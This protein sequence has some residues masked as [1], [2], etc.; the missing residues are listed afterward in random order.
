MKHL[1]PAHPLEVAI[2]RVGGVSKLAL[3]LGVAQSTISNWRARGTKIDAAHC[4]SIE[5]AT[6]GA[7]TR[8]EL[9]PDDWQDIWP[10]LA[11][12]E[13]AQTPAPTHATLAAI[14]CA[15]QAVV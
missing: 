12:A 9:R 6:C 1:T 13:P 15:Q 3:V 8:R 11:V 4:V 14:P 5:R 2:S 10:E 7:I